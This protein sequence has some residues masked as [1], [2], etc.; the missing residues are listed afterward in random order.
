MPNNRKSTRLPP[1]FYRGQRFHFVTICCDRRRPYLGE[2]AT[3]QSVLAIL[4]QCAAKHSFLLRAFCLMPDHL[5]LLAQGTNATCD[6]LEFV[7]VFKLRAAFDF[8]KTHGTRLWEK[9]YYD[10]TLRQADAIEDVACYIWQNPVRKKLCASPSD[11]PFS[12]SKTIAWMRGT[13]VQS[14]WSAAWK[15]K[16]PV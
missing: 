7:R 15:A 14:S 2:R 3:A 11:F 5:H 13:A 9:S 8:K 1:E 6:L 4:E 16:A 12:G 10:H